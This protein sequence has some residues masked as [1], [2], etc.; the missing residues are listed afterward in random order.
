MSGPDVRSMIAEVERLLA[1]GGELPEQAALAIEKLLN[2]VEA[3]SADRQALA[4]EVNRLRKKLDEK[5][6]SKTT[7]KPDDKQDH[8]ND[9]QRSSSDHSSEKQRRKRLKKQLKKGQDRRSFK[10]LTIHDAVECPVD[11]ATLPPDAVRVDD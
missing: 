1:E 8:A 6:K 5:K 10:D 7:A 2:V 3:L 4:D 9:D 11:P